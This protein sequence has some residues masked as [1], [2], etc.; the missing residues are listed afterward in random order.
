[1]TIH[2]IPSHPIPSIPS[3][4]GTDQSIIRSHPFRGEGM[5]LDP[6]IAFLIAAPG[7]AGMDRR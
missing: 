1:M 4:V 2:T 7:L 5:G 3:D 6:G